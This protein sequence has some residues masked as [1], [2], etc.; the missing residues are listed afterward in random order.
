MFGAAVPGLFAAMTSCAMSES[1]GAG[2]AASTSRSIRAT[3]AAA[4]A[5]CGKSLMSVD[6]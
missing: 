4:N 1:N 5:G 3:P 6:M 2:T